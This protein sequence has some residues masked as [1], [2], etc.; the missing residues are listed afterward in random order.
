MTACLTARLR[1]RCVV[2]LSILGALACVP[3]PAEAQVRA[4][5]MADVVCA[6][7]PMAPDSLDRL[8]R[9][10]DY[11]G[12]MERLAE[13]CPDIAMLFMEFSVGSIDGFAETRRSPSEPLIGPLAWPA[14][15][16]R[17]Y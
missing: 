4:K 17:N 5:A 6:S 11:M 13:A 16:D 8:K 2:V 12:L 14:P 1:R 9:R 15:S 7:P 10:S 3:L